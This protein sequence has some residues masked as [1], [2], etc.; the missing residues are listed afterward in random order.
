MRS[1]GRNREQRARAM[2]SDTPETRY[3]TVSGSDVAYKVI[4]DGPRDLL[5]FRGVGSQ[6]DS[7]WDDPWVAQ[8]LDGFS[9]FSRI[10]VF[11][12]RGTGASDRLPGNAVATWEDWT[13]D[14]SAVLSAVGSE[15]VAID[16]VLDAGPIA[17][18]FAAMHP[19]RVSALVLNNTT[20]RY[21][22]D[23]DYPAGVS[24]ATLNAVVEAVK[25]LW[26][27]PRFAGLVA[28]ENAM[29]G[30]FVQRGARQLR[31]STTPANAAAQVRYILETLDV[32]AFLPSLHVPT[33][34]LHTS[35]NPLIPV[36]QGRFLAEHIRGARFVEVPGRGLGFDDDKLTVVLGEIAEFLTGERPVTHVDRVLTT[37]MFTDIVASTDTAAALGDQQWRER[38]DAHDNIVR[39]ELARTDGHAVHHTGDGFLATFDGPARAINCARAIIQRAAN[40]GIRIRA[41]I[42]VG[43][44]ERRGND[45]AGIAI[46]IGA[47]VCA[48]APPGHVLVTATVKDLTAGSG[49]SFS[50]YGN[51]DLKGVPERRQ[52][53]EVS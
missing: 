33:L 11:D 48:L 31:A 35:H 4:G 3:V 38:L 52:L 14:V 46:H 51:H 37:V 50:Y 24:S 23:D 43:E 30:E 29:D 39:S 16:A 18:L 47:R 26:G 5:F 20:A 10:I 9:S 36:E 21:L 27:S 15:Q 28:P 12:P 7:L 19:A 53:Y 42:H 6:I 49:I 13:H 32:R 41:G 22:V 17:V 1:R 8:L 2:H 34:V 40:V 45:L 25:N 44:C